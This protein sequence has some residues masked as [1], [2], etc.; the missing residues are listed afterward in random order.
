MSVLLFP[1]MQLM[2]EAITLRS[3]ADSHDL[4]KQGS[5][6]FGVSAFRVLPAPTES[7]SLN[8]YQAALD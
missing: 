3:R 8:V 2:N 6:M 5:Q 7:L 1:R 4:K